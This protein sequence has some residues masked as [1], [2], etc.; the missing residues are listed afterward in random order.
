[1][2]QTSIVNKELGSGVV[3]EFYSTEPQRTREKLLESAKPAL[4]KIGVAVTQVENEDDQVGV[5]A[6]RVFAGIIGSPKSLV[7]QGLD[8]VTTIKNGVLVECY[9][10]GYMFVDLPASAAIGDYV[11]YS[12]ADGTLSSSSPV[13]P[14][15]AGT[16]RVPGG[17]VRIKN[18]LSSGIAI[19][20]LDDAGDKT[21][22]A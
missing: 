3:G 17:T 8:N 16:T 20:Y 2:G 9:L 15:P 5:G 12:N 18:V 14:A 21:Q 22:P 19:I 11:Y 6:S 4:N 10:Q 13:N 1:M 7:R